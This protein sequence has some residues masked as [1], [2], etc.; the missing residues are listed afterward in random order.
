MPVLIYTAGWGS[1]VR[2]KRLAQEHK[3][4]SWS[5]GDE[6]TNHEAIIPPGHINTVMQ[7]QYSSGKIFLVKAKCLP[8]YNMNSCG[9]NIQNKQCPS[10]QNAKQTDL[11]NVLSQ[12]CIQF[13][14]NG[15][16][17]QFKKISNLPHRRDFFK[18]SFHLSGNSKFILSLINFFKF[19]G[20]TDHP[21]LQRNFNHP[22]CGRIRNT[23]SN[24][25]ISRFQANQALPTLACCLPYSHVQFIQIL[26]TSYAIML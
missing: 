20:L 8:A 17:Y 13:Y 10:A 7:V 18:P 3:T 24:C 9:K 21:S 25:T 6:C 15:T 4:T 26:L 16:M 1:T 11:Q 12:L 5:F 19:L 14:Q 2:V 23:F 22:F